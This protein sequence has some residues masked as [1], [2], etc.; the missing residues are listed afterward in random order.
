MDVKVD[1]EPAPEVQ[2]YH[3]GKTMSPKL[4]QN[5]PYLTKLIHET[6][7]RSDT[8]VYKIIATNKYGVDQVEFQINVICK[9]IAW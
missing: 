9:Y 7:K 4:Y 1:G 3:D 6:P 8:G 2:W 5:V